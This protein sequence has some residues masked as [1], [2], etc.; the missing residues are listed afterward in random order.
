MSVFDV[1]LLS[2]F[3]KARLRIN[4]SLVS[5]CRA[6]ATD[7]VE[8]SFQYGFEIFRAICAVGEEL[9]HFFYGNVDLFAGFLDLGAFHGKTE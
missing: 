9:A 8:W 7:L 2:R 4:I 3:Y 5:I 1:V 6:P